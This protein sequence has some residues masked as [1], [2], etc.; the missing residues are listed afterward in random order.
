M[1]K[2]RFVKDWTEKE[3]YLSSFSG[4]RTIMEHDYK[5]GLDD[6]NRAPYFTLLY[7]YEKG[8]NYFIFTQISRN[9]EDKI[10][11]VSTQMLI[12]KK[13]EDVK[14]VARN[15]FFDASDDYGNIVHLEMDVD[16]EPIEIMSTILNFKK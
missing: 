2:T 5:N 6:E 12:I 16:H 11:D 9:I 10:I 15:R 13:H 1:S 8:K 4:Y 14:V 7:K 3:K